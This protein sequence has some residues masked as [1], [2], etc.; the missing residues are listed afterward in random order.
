MVSSLSIN[1]IKMKFSAITTV[2]G[3]SKRIYQKMC[4]GRIVQFKNLLQRIIDTNKNIG[5]NFSFFLF[6]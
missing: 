2:I 1:N 3:Y 6:S 4:G 5:G